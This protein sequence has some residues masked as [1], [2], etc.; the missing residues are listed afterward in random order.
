MKELALKQIDTFTTAPFRG[1]PAGIVLGADELDGVAMQR[2]AAEMATAETAFV[3]STG[4]MTIPWRARFFTPN[5]E[6]DFSGHSV[7]AV[8]YALVEEG[9]VELA[10]GVTSLLVETKSGPVPIDIH[11]RSI[12][13]GVSPGALPVEVGG[14]TAGFLERIMLSLGVSDHRDATVPL[15]EIAD[16]CGI[17]PF[18]V[19]RTGLP[20][21]VVRN[22]IVQLLVPVQH[23]EAVR[24]MH[25]DLIRLM[26]MNQRIGVDTTDIFTLDALNE[27]AFTYS[28][29]FSPAT[30]L[31][32][33]IASGAGAASLASY[34]LRHGVITPR[35]M[36]MDQGNEID[37]LA[38]VFVEVEAEK[39]GKVPVRIGG[40]AVTSITR[41]VSIEDERVLIA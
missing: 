34:L 7:I 40:L 39:D 38:R 18:E 10:D 1:N 32:E 41:T 15:E 3:Q 26:L 36:I 16:I 30:G 11:F 8:A 35:T 25:P 14:H 17:D 4:S 22:G 31:W 27:D 13:S 21:E 37:S 6:Y 19:K 24:E 29:H 5:C 12:A 23:A 33:D 2:I 20:V 9:L 28:R